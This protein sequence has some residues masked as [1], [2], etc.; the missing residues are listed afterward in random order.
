MIPIS[1]DELPNRA[2]QLAYFLHRERKT[3]VDIAVRALNK[4]Q[5]AATAQGKRLYYRLTGRADARKARSKVSL[6][7]PHLLQRLVYIESEE[8][9]RRREAAAHD[10]QINSGTTPARQSDLGSFLHQTPGT[11]Y[12]SAQFVL[13]NVGPESSA[14]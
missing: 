5:L 13:C 8:Y 11:H 2:F 12:H 3:A 14:L 7:E 9:E 4:L 10:P 1:P 6:G